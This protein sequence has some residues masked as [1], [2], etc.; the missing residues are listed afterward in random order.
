MRQQA[1]FDSKYFIALIFSNAEW[2]FMSGSKLPH[3]EKPSVIISG[4]EDF[5]ALVDPVC[6]T[7]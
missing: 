7:W 5:Q 6:N 3:L 4:S 1:Y 2:S